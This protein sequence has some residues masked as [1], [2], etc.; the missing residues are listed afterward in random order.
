MLLVF[1]RWFVCIRFAAVFVLWQ[2]F[3]MMAPPFLFSQKTKILRTIFGLGES[4]QPWSWS[5]VALTILCRWQHVFPQWWPQCMFLFSC[6]LLMLPFWGF[7]EAWPLQYIGSILGRASTCFWRFLKD[8]EI[9]YRW[10]DRSSPRTLFPGRI[11]LSWLSLWKLFN[12]I[13]NPTRDAQSRYA[14]RIQFHN[15]KL[16][17]WAFRGSS[18][19]RSSI[20]TYVT[21]RV[22]GCKNQILWEWITLE[23]VH[24]QLLTPG[25]WRMSWLTSFILALYFGFFMTI[26]PKKLRPRAEKAPEN[27]ALSPVV[28]FFLYGFDCDQPS[29]WN[30][31]K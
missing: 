17:V 4:L 27:N 3:D 8:E 13:R 16:I 9:F 1:C 23:S 14:Q 6:F 2:I 7:K 11:C 29:A 26:C 10:S 30:S 22:P 28:T 12:Q 15:Q 31:S 25:G 21:K 5:L 18:S 19:H 24:D 20:F